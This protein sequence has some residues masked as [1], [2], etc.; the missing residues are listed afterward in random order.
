MKPEEELNCDNGH[1]AKMTR[2]SQCQEGSWTE[3][4]WNK[5]ACC[6]PEDKEETERSCHEQDENTCGTQ[7]RSA[8]CTVNGV[9]SY[10]TWSATC[11]DKPAATEPCEE[12]SDLMKTRSVECVDN[13]WVVGETWDTSNC[14]KECTK[15][16]PSTTPTCDAYYNTSGVYCGTVTQDVSCDYTTG[17]WVTSNAVV[18]CSKPQS[19]VGTTQTCDAYNNTSWQYCGTKTLVATC[20]AGAWSYSWSGSCQSVGYVSSTNS[21]TCGKSYTN[22]SAKYTKKHVCNGGNS[23]SDV[24]DY[25]ACGCYAKKPA[26][27]YVADGSCPSGY[28]QTTAVCSD[29]QTWDTSVTCVTGAQACAAKYRVV[30]DL[31]CSVGYCEGSVSDNSCD[32][33]YC[34]EPW[35]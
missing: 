15:T 4:E 23:W 16:K 6:K 10:G 13:A 8:S 17:E 2:T 25:T 21:Y 18:N 35:D 22:S 3:P 1:S 27:E 32:C 11:E 30:D 7:S 26:A 14:K 28:G 34:V 12:G 24:Y 20:N 19:N 31:I 33:W 9:W 29:G 5:S